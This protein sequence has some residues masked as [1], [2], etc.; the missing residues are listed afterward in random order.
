MIDRHEARN[1]MIAAWRGVAERM[2]EIGCD[3]SD[4]FQTMA[5]VGLTGISEHAKGQ[6]A[7]G[8]QDPPMADLIAAT[9]A[10][11]A[12]TGRVVSH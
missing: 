10:Q 9:G 12:S 6:D 1:K 7:A 4:I 5:L 11:P 3:P 2:I 8:S